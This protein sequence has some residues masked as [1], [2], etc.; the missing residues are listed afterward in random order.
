[1]SQAIELSMQDSIVAYVAD[2][3]LKAGGR[4]LSQYVVVFPGVRPCL[5]LRH[6]L[7]RRIGASYHPPHLLDVDSFISLV[8]AGH[9]HGRH[10]R[11]TSQLNLLYHL[12][13]LV[14]GVVSL[15]GLQNSS[16]FSHKADEVSIRHIV[17]DFEDFFYW[18]LE[19]LKVF[20]DFSMEL[21]SPASVRSHVPLALKEDGLGQEA[22]GIWPYLAE[23]YEKW[24]Q[25]LDEKG[26]WTRGERYRLASE[27]EE[28]DW[29]G[30]LRTN[31]NMVPRI[32]LAGFFAF[33]RAEE[34]VFGLLTR[35]YGAQLIRYNEAQWRP[36]DLK[37]YETQGFHAQLAVAANLFQEAV[38]YNESVKHDLVA[39]VLPDSH[40]LIPVL[41]WLL[42]SQKMP[43]NISMG[44]PLERLAIVELTAAILSLFQSM[45]QVGNGK[46]TLIYLLDLLR[47]LSHAQMVALQR[48]LWPEA[49][50]SAGALLRSWMEEQRISF[51]LKE[52]VEQVFAQVEGGLAYFQTVFGRLEPIFRCRTIESFSLSI[53]EFVTWLFEHTPSH[54]SGMFTLWQ[55]GNAVFLRILQ[56][57]GQSE[58][59]NEAITPGGFK[60]LLRYVVSRNRLAFKGIPL[61]G[62]QVL[63]LLETRCLNFEQVFV[64]DVNE[65]VLPTGI[66]VNSILP[67]GLRHALGMPGAKRTVEI[68]RHH[69]RRLMAG[70][71]QVYLFY[72]S[73][74]K[75]ERSRFIDEILWELEKEQGRLLEE[76]LVN[77][78]GL[79]L[80]LDRPDTIQVSKEQWLDKL[81]HFTYSPHS[82]DLYLKCPYKFYLKYCL[83]I[84]D[85]KT[86]KAEIDS[87]IIGNII[88]E[89]LYELYKPFIGKELNINAIKKD[90]EAILIHTI[91]KYF[92]KRESVSI[93]L[94]KEILL[95]R[96][97][98]FLEFEE[99][100][101]QG[102]IIDKLEQKMQRI[103]TLSNIKC[104]VSI[105]GRVDR[106]HTDL[107]GKKWIIDY[108]T[109]DVKH[110][111]M[112]E[113]LIDYSRE[114]IKNTIS[115]LQLPIYL[116]LCHT[117]EENEMNAA[118]YRLKG[119]NTQTQ[120]K[121]IVL[122][123]LSDE[124][125]PHSLMNRF[126][127][128]LSAI[129]EEL[130]NEEIPFLA[131]TSDSDYC[132]YCGYA[133]TL[134][135]AV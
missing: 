122:P 27:L 62:L 80:K 112:L 97:N 67:Q 104:D 75:N 31:L 47:V 37:V 29:S 95:H 102:V 130:L 93:K 28:L 83:C 114:T 117:N 96:L 8:A 81:R 88:H 20:E 43:F 15:D 33:T 52:E 10:R 34:Q 76:T 77:K 119:L 53:T 84:S 134:C 4:D 32:Y 118:Y 41:Y 79:Y 6:E 38:R 129:L 98:L 17:K 36:P 71:K 35:R 61:K 50:F 85:E 25:L 135:K 123:L 22:R 100:Y 108:K 49:D 9:L 55:N 48:A 3:L 121:N 109:G 74:G 46:E 12:F 127:P 59:R 110:R 66:E 18:G 16:S 89:T 78:T 13:E 82:I 86:I 54:D 70:A 1:M 90:I 30:I 57:L 99:K 42:N 2:L 131:D 24:L 56:E 26:F 92:R 124:P 132:G 73:S 58:L 11:E 72:E 23:L 39:F 133:K 101:N 115:S 107:T 64:F 91:E 60:R 105:A 126:L 7:S 103:L 120:E 69:F 19:L 106:I 51:A 21:V 116:W 87:D 40:R 113:K 128:A 63:G 125:S 65:G 111:F 14:K 5:Y 68:E 44:Y 45:R 94:L